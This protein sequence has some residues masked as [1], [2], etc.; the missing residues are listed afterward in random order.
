MAPSNKFSFGKA[1]QNVKLG[2]VILTVE[3]PGPGK[4]TLSGKG[5]AKQASPPPG[6]VISKTAK[7]AGPVKLK[8]KPKGATEAKLNA[9][10]R[11]TVKV[12]VTFAPI[13]GAATTGQRSVMLN[14]RR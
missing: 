2:I 1:K 3:V 12:R 7:A 8:V 13:G 6:A 14:K 11:A 9:R 5:V 10:G 4:L